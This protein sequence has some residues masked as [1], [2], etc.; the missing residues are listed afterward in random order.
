M[1]DS[2][3]AINICLNDKVVNK[4]TV[5]L[6]YYW[7]GTSSIK[8]SIIK[9]KK[10]IDFIAPYLTKDNYTELKYS[11]FYFTYENGEENYHEAFGSLQDWLTLY[12]IDPDLRQFYTEYLN[13]HF[14]YLYKCSFNMDFIF[15]T[16][17]PVSNILEIYDAIKEK[18]PEKNITK[19]T[20]I[21]YVR[22]QL[23]QSNNLNTVNTDFVITALYKILE[24]RL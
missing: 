8:D 9:D 3:V 16:I 13:E 15:N 4:N 24:N 23:S 11:Y 19:S 5:P 14:N 18:Y 10:F 7:D 6:L 22:G 1:R 2:L 21:N 17:T 20:V 12:D